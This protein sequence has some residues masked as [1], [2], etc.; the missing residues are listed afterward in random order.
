MK[1]MILLIV[2]V[3]LSFS[4]CIKVYHEKVDD[5]PKTTQQIVRENEATK[6]GT[7]VFLLV[8]FLVIVVPFGLLAYVSG[9]ND[10][11]PG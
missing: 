4:S 3:V 9:D 6:K 7:E 11:G 1:K 2:F 5:T 10:N 8:M